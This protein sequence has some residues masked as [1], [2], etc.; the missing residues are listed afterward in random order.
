MSSKK[1][2]SKKGTL[3]ANV[4]EEL[5]VPKIKFVPHAVDPAENEAWWVARYGSITPPNEKS[6]P[7]MNRRL[8]EEVAPSRSTSDFLQTVRSFYQIPDTVYWS[9]AWSSQRYLSVFGAQKRCKG[10][11]W[12]SRALG[13]TFPERHRQVTL[14]CLIRATLPERRGE[15][16]CVFIARRH[17][18]GPRETS[19]SDPS[20]SLPKHGA[21]SR[22]DYWRSLC[23]YCLLEF[24]FTQGPFGHFIMHVF[25]F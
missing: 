13:A 3:S 19:R 15:V 1:K 23:T 14:T 25:T 18:N 20:R 22:S 7:V 4:H 16:A 10:D 21:T 2:I 5:L 6:F 11:H 17:E 24:M 9:T 8:V 12:T